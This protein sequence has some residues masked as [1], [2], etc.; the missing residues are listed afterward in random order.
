M[1]EEEELR[2]LYEKLLEHFVLYNQF[3]NNIPYDRAYEISQLILR[4]NNLAIKN[5]LYKGDLKRSLSDFEHKL[6]S[7]ERNRAVLFI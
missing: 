3:Q 1:G 2:K 6:E 4:I 5:G 7:E